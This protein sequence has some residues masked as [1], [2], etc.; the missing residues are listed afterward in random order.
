MQKILIIEDDKAY[1]DNIKILLE[2]E[3]YNI[4]SAEN[5]FD[6]IDIAKNENISLIICDIMLPD[7]DGYSILKELR[8]REKTKLIPFIFLT[9]KASMDDLRS[10]MNLGADDYLTKPFRS[11]DLLIAI[12]ARLEKSKII[13]D[14]MRKPSDSLLDNKSKLG[15]DDYLFLP[16]KNNYEVIP[17]NNVVY[18]ESA[19][20]YSN[21]FSS[22]GKKVL[23]RKLLKDWEGTLPAA[24]F[25]RIHKS[26]LVNMKHIK[27]VEK[28]F[29][30]TLKLYLHNY[31]ESLIVSRRYAARLKKS[32]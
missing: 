5:G 29:N 14:L 16:F 27:K 9:A 25:I 12:T 1:I 4:I 20:V 13:N 24:I 8:R 11:E 2:E 6:G 15:P 30:G 28:W 18:I 23:V 7:I 17:V 22:D 10:G 19:G 3:G 21:V 31:T 32:I 26:F